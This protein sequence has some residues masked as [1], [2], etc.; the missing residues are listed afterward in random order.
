[1]RHGDVERAVERVVALR[2]VV[3]AVADPAA[4]RRLDGVIRDLRRDIGVGVPKR[5]AA[6]V[7]GVSVQALERWVES[8]LLPVVRRPGSTRQLIDAETLI[9]L[10]GEVARRRS[11]GEERGVV[12]A[13]LRELER[14]GRLPRKLRPNETASELRRSFLATTP[15][16]RLRDVAELSRTAVALAASGAGSRR[17]RKDDRPS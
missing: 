2:R 6:R 16:E 8:G 10:A 17:K 5:R 7:L 14:S 9:A 11:A 13:S 4:R 3:D 1:M 12:A 15:Q